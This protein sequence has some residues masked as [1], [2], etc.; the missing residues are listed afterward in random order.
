M[1]GDIDPLLDL[2]TAFYF[3]VAV[4]KWRHESYTNLR[5]TLYVD[6]PI[7]KATTDGPQFAKTVA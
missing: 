3:T 7:L 4:S 6:G 5:I 2:E 1:R